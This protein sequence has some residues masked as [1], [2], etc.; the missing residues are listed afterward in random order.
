MR[1]E[2]GGSCGKKIEQVDALRQMLFHTGEAGHVNEEQGAAPDSEAGENTG[3][4]AGQQ[5]KEP[6]FHNSA[7]TAP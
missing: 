5:G 2:R 3:S 6:F 4:R 1:G 7:F